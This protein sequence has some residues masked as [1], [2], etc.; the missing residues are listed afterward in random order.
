MEPIAGLVEMALALNDLLTAV[1]TADHVLAHLK[2]GGTLQ[3]TDE[4]LR[5]Y[6]VCYRALERNRDPRA[7]D[8]LFEA[9]RLLNSQLAKLRDG[10]S[11]QRFV[12]NAP[13]RLAIQQAQPVR[14]D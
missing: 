1:Q 4:P 12:E 2:S 9:V 13:W 11:R 3:G 10:H 7:D 14:C 5:I 8:L 6:Y